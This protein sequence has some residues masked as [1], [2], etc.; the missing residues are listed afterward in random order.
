MG[1][2]H[3]LQMSDTCSDEAEAARSEAEEAVQ[4]RDA[5]IAALKLVAGIP[6]A[7]PVR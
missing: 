3:F 5:E 1:G 7:A 4:T 2:R 6:T